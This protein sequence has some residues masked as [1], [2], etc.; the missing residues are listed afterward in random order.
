MIIT[1]NDE[2]PDEAISP[3]GERFGIS[4]PVVLPTDTLY[5]LA[6]PISDEKALEMI[7]DLKGR[8]RDVTLPIAVGSVGSI[9]EISEIT[10]EQM[11]IIE[12]VLPGPVTFI[13]QAKQGLSDIVTRGGTVA[14]RVVDHPV[15]PPLCGSFGPVAL[16][17]ANLHGSDPLLTADSIETYL[18]GSNILIVEDDDHVSDKPST[19]I[20]LTSGGPRVLRKGKININEL[21]GETDG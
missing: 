7:L 19:I 17:S 11:D 8:P 13:L 12:R 20:D 2:R 16:T 1:W 4:M 3:V 18:E 6:A 9:D 21:M 14:V 10:G 15:F 5:G